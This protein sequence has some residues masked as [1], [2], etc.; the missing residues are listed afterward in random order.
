MFGIKTIED[1][2]KVRPA[3]SQKMADAIELWSNMYEGN[4]PWLKEP[5][6]YDPSRTVSLGLPA[7]IASEKARMA[8]LEFESEITPP[9]EDVEKPNPEYEKPSV[10]P[11]G[12]VSMGRGQATITEPQPT[13]NPERAEYLNE[14]YKKLKKQ[15][16]RQLEYGV[17]KGGLVIKPYIVLYND[18]E[19]NPTVSVTE[20]KE[21]K[22]VDAQATPQQTGNS[23]RYGKELP[24]A[25]IEFDFVQA[26]RFYPL[27]FDSNGKVTEA[28][29]IQM[30]VKLDKVY[31]RMEHHK[32]ENRRVIVE[33]FAFESTDTGLITNQRITTATDLGNPV[34]LTQISDWA[35]LAPKVVIENVDRLLFAYFKMPEAN[36]VDTYS[37]LGVSCYSR[38][39][40]L[41]KDADE[42]YSR[43]LWEFEGSEL[44]IDVDRDAMRPQMYERKDQNG[45]PVTVLPTKQQRLFRKVDLNTEETYEVFSPAIRDESLI[46][47]LNQIL[48]RIEDEI[49]FSR[50]TISELASTSE[51]RT[52]TEMK[53]LKQRSFA[54][55]K[56]IQDSIQ[57]AL[58]DV[59][60]VMDVYCDLYNVTPSGEYEVSYEWD[61]SIIVDT[62]VELEK[63]LSMLDAGI[64][65][66][67]EIRMWYFGETENQ[68]KAAL[69]RVDD[70]RKLSMETNIMAQAE[71]GQTMQGQ[72][73]SGSNNPGSQRSMGNPNRLNNAAEKA[74]SSNKQKGT[75]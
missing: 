59:V 54:A 48:M 50:G 5:D 15:L 57:D 32:L 30:I 52:A 40:D 25:D 47:G 12:T 41:I 29:F 65:S 42:Q 9:M 22:T 71:L 43:L 27:A 45:R 37:P 49:G 18:Q 21:N 68:A 63:K 11:D 31:T 26:D 33:N 46:N 20:S 34:P 24:K 60:Y 23:L 4:S 51:A 53:I 62:D 28:A 39:V 58:D 10:N 75:S 6:Y 35:N 66:K 72:D 74:A 56:H 69:Q 19:S 8:L 17:A 16:R 14:Q 3:I 73:V 2:I 61:D 64:T 38:V 55:N 44:A 1:V 67:L 70:E 36:T 13:C 7:L